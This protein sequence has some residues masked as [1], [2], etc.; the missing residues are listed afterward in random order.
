MTPK[1]LKIRFLEHDVTQA[2]VAAKAGVTRQTVSLVCNG[3]GRSRRVEEIVAQAL[4]LPRRRIFP[5]TPE[6]IQSR[7]HD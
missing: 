6:P 1:E 4:G 3:H 2:Q 5:I 7:T